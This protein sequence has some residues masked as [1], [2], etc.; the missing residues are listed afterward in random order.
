MA[1]GDLTTLADVKAW[2]PD[3]AAVTASDGVLTSLITAASRFVCN[4]TGRSL[5]DVL[6]YSEDYDGNGAS[7]L[8]L[9][10]WPAMA[11]TSLAC[12]GQPVAAAVPGVSPF[13]G[14]HLEP[15]LA[16]GGH[17]RLTLY[18]GVLPRGRSNVTVSY[19]AGYDAIPADVAQ[20]TIELVGERFRTRDRIGQTSKT[21][22]GQET[23]A[24]SVK[25][26]NDTIQALLAPHRRLI[27]C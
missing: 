20:A 16:A 8:L 17:Q 14:Y 21:L 25:D 13:S 2:L 23:T 7:F 1:D 22:G 15:P 4:Y 12:D 26:M 3:M 6:S 19:A 27:P 24:F 5:F 9:R 10:Q 11:I 18:G